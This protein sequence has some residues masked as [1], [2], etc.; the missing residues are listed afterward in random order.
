M[1][2][3]ETSRESKLNYPREMPIYPCNP[4]PYISL[5]GIQTYN[6]LG[7]LERERVNVM[8]TFATWQTI[9]VNDLK[10]LEQLRGSDDMSL[11]RHAMKEQDIGL[12]CYQ[13]EENLTDAELVLLKKALR[14]SELRWRSFKSKLR[15][16]QA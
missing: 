14:L 7:A 11:M 6:Y 9:L 16:G 13:A 3:A 12:H 1:S 2:I 15:P 10:V 5:G 4:S 8:E